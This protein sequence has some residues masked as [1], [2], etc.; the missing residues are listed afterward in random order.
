MTVD[1]RDSVVNMNVMIQVT[2]P[3]MASVT[4][5]D[6]AYV[7]LATPVTTVVNCALV[8]GSARTTLGMAF[9]CAQ[10]LM[11]PLKV[12]I[13]DV[14]ASILAMTMVVAILANQCI[15]H[16]SV[17][18]LTRDSRVIPCGMEHSVNL[19]HVLGIAPVTAHVIHTITNV[20][21]SQVGLATT[22]LSLT[23]RPIRTAT[24]V[25]TATLLTMILLVV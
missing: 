12:A 4:C 18:I 2:V 15:M 7:T 1:I 13:M 24:I 23:A 6:S 10:L 14:S 25:V 11:A 9:V 3:D 16:A 19:G 20:C 21:V 8:K 5:L 17:K 22:A